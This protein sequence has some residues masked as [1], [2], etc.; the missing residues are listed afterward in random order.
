MSILMR[1][2]P[3][4]LGAAGLVVAVILSGLAITAPSTVAEDPGRALLTRLEQKANG[5]DTVAKAL[6]D[7]IDSFLVARGL[8]P[9][10]VKA[11]VLAEDRRVGNVSPPREGRGAVLG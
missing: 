2:R 5:G 11:S 7:D 3:A 4:R 1:G 9:R 10:S 8:D 6:L